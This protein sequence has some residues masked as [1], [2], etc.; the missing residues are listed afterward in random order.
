V[1]NWQLLERY[2]IGAGVVA[3][4][5]IGLHGGGDLQ[6]LPCFSLGRSLLFNLDFRKRSESESKSMIVERFVC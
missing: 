4:A 6:Q 2:H 3:V 1:D 5:V